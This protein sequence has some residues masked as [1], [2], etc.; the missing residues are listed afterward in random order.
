MYIKSVTDTPVAIKAYIRK[1]YLPTLGVG[2]GLAIDG[3]S[4]FYSFS[5]V[6]FRKECY[7]VEL[8][9]PYLPW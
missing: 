3:N 1:E 5:V 2:W 8:M 6:S 7:L 4:S 9:S